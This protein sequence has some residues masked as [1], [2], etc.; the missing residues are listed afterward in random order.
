MGPGRLA[1]GGGDMASMGWFKRGIPDTRAGRIVCGPVDNTPKQ[2]T[3][4]G[5]RSKSTLRLI[6]SARLLPQIV[7]GAARR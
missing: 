6:V 3:A 2:I 5:R 7:A 1:R 4:I